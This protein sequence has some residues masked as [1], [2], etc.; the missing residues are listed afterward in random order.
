MADTTGPS[1]PTPELIAAL[2]RG[3]AV[4]RHERQMMSLPEKVRAV[5]E[6]QRAYLPL[7]AKQR[8]LRPWE[9]VWEADNQSPAHSPPVV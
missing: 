4:L 3:K 7:L 8:P 5:I 9:R 1:R 6:L 2:R